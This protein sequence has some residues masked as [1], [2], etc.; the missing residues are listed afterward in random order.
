[1]KALKP[2]GG[3]PGYGRGTGIPHP[4]DVHVGGRIR[5]RRLFL[6]MKQETL[7]KALGVS[8]QQV[9]KY[10]ISA[11]R[12]SASRLSAI[13]DALRVPIS[14]FFADLPTDGDQSSAMRERMYLPETIELVRLYFAIP[15]IELRRRFLEMVKAVAGATKSKTEA[16]RLRQAGDRAGR[17]D[18]AGR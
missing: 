18:G 16:L 4:I 13:A 10:E 12:V 6:G 14:F 7:A 1:L 11:N 2:A 9:Q 5:M 3:R 8:F 17:G 15:D